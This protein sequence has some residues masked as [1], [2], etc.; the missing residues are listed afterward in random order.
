MADSLFLPTF[1]S[2]LLIN[3][4]ILLKLGGGIENKEG[5]VKRRDPGYD[6]LEFI[7]LL[8]D[9]IFTHLSPFAS[10]KQENRKKHKLLQ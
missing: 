6:I 4:Q 2:A 8:V 9:H 3:V 1:L 10:R 5:R 7:D